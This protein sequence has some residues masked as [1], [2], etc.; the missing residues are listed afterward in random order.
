MGHRTNVFAL[1]QKVR[2]RMPSR[3]SASSS[4]IEINGAFDIQGPEGTSR[5]LKQLWNA[6]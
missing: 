1:D 6:N 2:Q 4:T 3:A 5:K